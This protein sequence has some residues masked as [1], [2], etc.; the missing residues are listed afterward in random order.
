M[1]EIKK[2][3]EPHTYVWYENYAQE[4]NFRLTKIAD[5]VIES[6][7][8]CFGYCPC[9]Y[10]FYVKDEKSQEEFDKILCPCQYILEDMEKCKGKT[11]TCHC[12]LFEK[13]EQN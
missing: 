2:D 13:I 12:H 7:N 4:N 8:K 6:V 1:S 5:K 11:K 3:Y 10:S 9:R